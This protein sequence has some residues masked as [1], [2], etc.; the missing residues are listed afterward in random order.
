[1][2]FFNYIFH[3]RYIHNRFFKRFRA[4]LKSLLNDRSTNTIL[5]AE[6]DVQIW[7]LFLTFFFIL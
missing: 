6:N 5:I 7:Q 2:D 1:M 4:I 3:V